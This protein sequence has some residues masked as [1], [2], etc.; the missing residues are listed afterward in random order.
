M[1]IQINIDESLQD[2][3]VIIKCPEMDET[4]QT[5]QK[6]ISDISNRK[7]NLIFYQNEKEFYFSFKSIL[8]FETSEN[9]VYAHTK[10]A[11]YQVQ[12]K[13]YELEEILP[14]YFMR[15]SK[16]TIINTR[17]IYSITKNITSSSK[18]EF[19]GSHKTVYVSR[20]YY[21]ALKDTLRDNRL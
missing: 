11:I 12:H 14:A 19:R 20:N 7:S 6:Y 3:E 2:L 10:D 8:F 18:V 1:K 9:K 15:I 21:K 16:S 4:V 5:L 17:E 13:L